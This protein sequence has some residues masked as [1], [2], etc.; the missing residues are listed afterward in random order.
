MVKTI[1]QLKAEIVRQRKRIAQETDVAEVIA[2]KQKLS[3]TLFQLRNKKLIGFGAKA[4]RL[5]KQFGKRV[6]K[7]GKI[8]APAIQKQAKLIREQ[9]LRDD[10][11]ERARAKKPGLTKKTTF[12]FVPI[13]KRK[14]QKQRFK[15]VKVIV[16]IPKKKPINEQPSEN[17][18]GN[19][20]F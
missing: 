10:A 8:I 16:K 12:K 4:R 17:I 3:R 1:A 20:D 9:Q 15:R 2:E 5:S 6:L 19:F 18:F 7:A 11:I 14:G 13:K